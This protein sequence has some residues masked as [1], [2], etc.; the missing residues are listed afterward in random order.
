MLTLQQM[1]DIAVRYDTLIAH[2]LIR[3]CVEKALATGEPLVVPVRRVAPDPDP[4]VIVEDEET[5]GWRRMM[6]TNR[7]AWRRR[8]R[9]A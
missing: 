9:P 1:V 5:R 7:E 6:E 3:A 2:A 4:F 8:R